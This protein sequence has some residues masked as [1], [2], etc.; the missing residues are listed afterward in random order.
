VKSDLQTVFTTGGKTHRKHAAKQAKNKG[1]TGSGS[2]LNPA[3]FSVREIIQRTQN[4]MRKLSPDQGFY[5][6]SV[7]RVRDLILP[8]TTAHKWTALRFALI[9]GFLLFRWL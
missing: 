3:K 6:I 2:A 9:P 1:K 8:S 7:N 5:T 4:T